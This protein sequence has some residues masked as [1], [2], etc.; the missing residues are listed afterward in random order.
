MKERPILYSAPMVLARIAGLKR[1]TR[2]IVKPKPI[3]HPWFWA[4]D[5]VDPDPQWFD[6]YERGREPC[7]AA[8][9]EVKT[10]M[11]CPYGQP[12][13]R[14]WGR[15]SFKIGP[16]I[17]GPPHDVYY[18]L[19]YTADGHTVSRSRSGAPSRAFCER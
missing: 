4:G 17:I 3:G 11:R 9:A 2:R 12:G 1:Q 14:V 7:G 10:P 6:C 16:E 15:E 5:D 8:T 18:P 19:I 13:D